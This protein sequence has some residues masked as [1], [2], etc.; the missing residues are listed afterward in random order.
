MRDDGDKVSRNE[1]QRLKAVITV[2]GQFN[3]P[4]EPMANIIGHKGLPRERYDESLMSTALAEFL[5]RT[6]WNKV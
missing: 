1:A 4:G 6:P 2:T 3:H 5:A